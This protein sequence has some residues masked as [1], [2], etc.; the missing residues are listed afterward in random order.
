MFAEG[1]EK[2][3]SRRR[4]AEMQRAGSSSLKLSSSR[5][6]LPVIVSGCPEQEKP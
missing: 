3:R 6:T 1:N 5:P 2:T 4:H